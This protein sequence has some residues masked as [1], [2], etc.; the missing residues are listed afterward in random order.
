[1]ATPAE[2]TTMRLL[3]LP[4]DTRALIVNADD[5]G[6]CHAN[7]GAIC[8]AL[9]AGIVT[10]TSLMT[11]CAWAPGAL[12]WL[13]DH[14]GTAFAV[15]LTLLSD[16][17]PYRWGPVCPRNQVPTLVDETGFFH[18][19]DRRAELLAKATLE[20]VE[21]EFRAQIGVVQAA[22]LAPT[23][24]DWHS[25]ADGGREDIF[26]LTVRLAREHGLAM[27]VHLPHHGAALRERCLPCVDYPVL[28]SYHIAAA[29]KPAHLARLLRD[30][31]PGLTEW[32]LHPSLGTDE[33]RAL[34]PE[35]WRVR[36]ADLDFALS[37]EARALIEE[38]GIVL[39]DYR[40]LQAAWNAVTG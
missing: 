26:D 14:P 11:P 38:E 25:L 15:H 17:A 32:A 33:A 7:N 39:L 29:D 6:M 24:L 3:G 36:R 10:S 5:Y 1:M 37:P 23:H 34:E 28:D 12:Q 13:A 16:F 4:A 9:D 30:L 27:R 2:S 21:A 31:P 40:T 18:L 22:G 20:E 19:W 35:N 8:Q